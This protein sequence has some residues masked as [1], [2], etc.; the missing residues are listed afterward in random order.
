MQR[1]R[2][3]RINAERQPIM[4]FRF[5]QLPGAVVPHACRDKLAGPGLP[6]GGSALCISKSRISKFGRSAALLTVH[7]RFQGNGRSLLSLSG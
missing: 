2:L 6:P 7:G 5:L 1:I 4:L 3:I